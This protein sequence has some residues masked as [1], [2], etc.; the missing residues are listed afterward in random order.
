MTTKARK[1]P[2]KATKE[3]KMQPKMSATNMALIGQQ[4][5]ITALLNDI[6]DQARQIKHGVEDIGWRAEGKPGMDAPM[7]ATSDKPEIPSEIATNRFLQGCL[8]IKEILS[9]VQSDLT[10]ITERFDREFGIQQ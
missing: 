5:T 1:K 9:T 4:P 8:D 6:L 2:S 3:T 10:S 7:T